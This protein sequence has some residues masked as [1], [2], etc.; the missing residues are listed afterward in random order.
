MRALNELLQ[1]MADLRDPQSGCPWDIAQ[2]FD[3]IKPYTIEEAYEVADAIERKDMDELKS[4]LGDLLFQVVF[5]AQMASEQGLFDFNEVVESV[6]EKLIRRHP[7]V[8]ADE[9]VKSHDHLA[10]RWEQH[11]QAERAEKQVDDSAL[12]GVTSALPA[13]QWSQ[14]LQKRAMRT[15]FDWP[16]IEP[17]FDKLN[18]EVAELREEIRKKSGHD[19]NHERIVDEYGDVLFVCANL[20]LHLKINAEQAMRQANRKFIDRFSLMEQLARGDGVVFEELS[21]ERMEEYWQKAKM[22]ISSAD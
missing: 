8:F 2:D 11:K 15:G 9:Q 7:H 16:D 5:H 6:N 20:G 22:K 4:E 10:E 17:V 3:S 14:K 18:E 19:D 21:L 1:I 12:S 13:L